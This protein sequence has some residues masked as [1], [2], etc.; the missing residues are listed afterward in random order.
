V[1]STGCDGD[2]ESVVPGD[3]RR[4]FAAGPAL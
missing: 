3:L 1:V 4:G 2:P